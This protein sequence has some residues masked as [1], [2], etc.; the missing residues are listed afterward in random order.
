MAAKHKCIL[1]HPDTDAYRPFRPVKPGTNWQNPAPLHLT[2]YLRN[3]NHREFKGHRFSKA[4]LP[5]RGARTVVLRGCR[6]LLQCVK[7]QA[8]LAGRKNRYRD[9]RENIAILSSFSIDA[10]VNDCRSEPLA[11]ASELA[12]RACPCVDPMPSLEDANC[13][14]DCSRALTIGCRSNCRATGPCRESFCR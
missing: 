1:E 13:R 9:S 12:E 8:Q 10:C 4:Y 11:T 7:Y 14:R 6:P 2:K 3:H 5:S